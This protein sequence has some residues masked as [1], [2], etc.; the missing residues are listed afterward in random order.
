M[1]KMSLEYTSPS[2]PFI[3]IVAS[4][5]VIG[6]AAGVLYSTLALLSSF[7]PGLQRL[8]RGGSL[9]VSD[10]RITYR[11]PLLAS[12]WKWYTGPLQSNTVG[13]ITV[14]RNWLPYQGRAA[15]YVTP[16]KVV[17]HSNAN[18]NRVT[19]AF[20]LSEDADYVER[21]LRRAMATASENGESR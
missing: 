1:V 10:G 16:N 9:Q 15:N 5:F 8:F 17:V 6:F 7:I 18:P 3:N 12:P 2:S 20:G 4:I 21:W 14:Y 19:L 11:P 13:D